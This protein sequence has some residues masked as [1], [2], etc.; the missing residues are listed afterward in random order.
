MLFIN[1]KDIDDLKDEIEEEFGL[2]PSK[3]RLKGQ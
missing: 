1:Q 3:K 2:K